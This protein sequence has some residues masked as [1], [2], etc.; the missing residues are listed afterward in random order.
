[1]LSAWLGA[2]PTGHA[3]IIITLAEHLV[4]EAVLLYAAADCTLGE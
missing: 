1:M 2:G 4:S 3:M